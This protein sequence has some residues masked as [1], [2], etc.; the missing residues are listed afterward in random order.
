MTAENRQ[1]VLRQRPQGIPKAEDFEFVRTSLGP[2]PAGRVRI[3]N[4]ALSVDP[5]M[6][7][8]LGPPGGYMPPVAIGEV[9][10]SF[11]VGEI[12]ESEDAVYAP[13]A[14]VVGMFGWQDFADADPASILWKVVDRNFPLS[15]SLGV[16]GINGIAAYVGT[17]EICRPKAGET[18]VVS[19][20]AG[21]VG[22]IAG[23]IAAI[24]GARV[25]GVAGG[26]GK[27]A[28]CIAD[29]GFVDCIDYKAAAD[30]D[31]DLA[32]ACPDGIDAYFDNTAGPIADAVRRHI[33]AGA[34]IALCGTA[35]VPGWSPWP[36]GD[37]VER[38]LLNKR[39][40]M[41]GFVVTDHAPRF[42]EILS[43]LAG[44]LHEGA[45]AHHEHRI[46]G[47]ERAPG[48]IQLLLEGRNEG[49]L[50]VGIA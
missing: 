43:R 40:L 38:H 29:Y 16:L 8:W 42:T 4:R 22:S 11:A 23:Q 26:A 12:V 32:R 41:Q 33:N 7:V 25:V 18:F 48:A 24:A 2:R 19:T 45:I 50:I 17:A 13:G 30:L 20:A 21:A 3:R 36:S 28:R 5:A 44:W 49:K 31:A 9:M 1:I 14:T 37:R 46:E 10:R 6:R 15:W 27:C 34:R 39:A 35:A 47:I